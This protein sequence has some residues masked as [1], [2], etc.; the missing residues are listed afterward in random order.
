MYHWLYFLFFTTF[1]NLTVWLPVKGAL[2]EFPFHRDPVQDVQFAIF[3][4]DLCLWSPSRFNENSGLGLQAALDRASTQLVAVV[5]DISTGKSTYQRSLKRDEKGRTDSTIY[6][7]SVQLL[8]STGDFLPYTRIRESI[9]VS[10][11]GGQFRRPL[12]QPC[13]RSRPHIFTRLAKFSTGMTSH[14]ALVKSHLLCGAPFRPPP[15]STCK[16][17]AAGTGSTSRT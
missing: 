5:P 16:G 9:V 2:N 12:V 6:S 8:C 10:S 3:S 4:D 15:L 11:L 1:L 13:K 7:R 17:F 14:S